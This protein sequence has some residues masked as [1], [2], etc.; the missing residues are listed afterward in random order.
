MV[1]VDVLVIGAGPTGLGA[2]QRASEL[3]LSYLVV[4]KAAGPGGMAASV[5]D[6]NGFTW[7]LGGHVLHSHFDHFDKALA[8]TGVSAANSSAPRFSSSSPNFP[9][10]CVPMPRR[11]TCSSTTATTAEPS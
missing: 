9:P 10:T 6:P 11:Q 4:E 5:T 3:G 1:G 7:D 8:D 2:A